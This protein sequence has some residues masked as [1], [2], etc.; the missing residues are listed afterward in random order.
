MLQEISDFLNFAIRMVSNGLEGTPRESPWEPGKQ[1][2]K[3]ML[4]KVKTVHY[5]IPPDSWVASHAGYVRGSR[6]SKA[7]GDVPQQKSLLNTTL[8]SHEG[9]PAIKGRRP[10]PTPSHP[11]L[12]I[13]AW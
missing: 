1:R 12:L 2:T 5:Q 3:A 8:P 10:S 13:S 7:T 4:R 11:R 6:V 9:I